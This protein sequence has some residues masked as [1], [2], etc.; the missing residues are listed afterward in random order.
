MRKHNF[1]NLSLT[2]L[3]LLMGLAVTFTSCKKD[4]PDP[5]PN[6]DIVL[7][8]TY[9]KG[10][11]TALTDYDS[12]GM[13]KIARN[14]VTQEDRAS[15]LEIYVAVKGGSDG[16]NIITVA[17]DVKTIMGPG[18]DFAEVTETDVDEPKDGLWRGSIVESE[19]KFTVPEDGLYH[20][21]YD[22]EIGIVTIAKADWGVIGA[23]TPGG[24]GESTAI[25]STGF[26]LNTI[27][28]TGSDI[29]MIKGDFKFR[30]SNGW[31]V[32]LDPE[33]DLGDGNTGIK[34]NSN[35]GGAVDNLVPGGANIVND[36]PGYYTI[37]MVWTIG[38]G[39]TATVEKTGD[40]EI[41]D[42][43]DTELGLVGDGLVV[44]G[45]P[46]NWD[47]TI[48]LSTPEVDGDTYTWTYAGVE[49]N[50]DGSFKIREGQDWNG[51]SVGY[52]DVTMGGT[53]ANNFEGTDPDGNFKALEAGIFDITFVIDAVTETYTFNV[54]VA[55]TADPELYMLGDG[56]A[57]GWDAENPIPM[58]GTDGLYTITADLTAGGE[59]IKFITT[60]GQWQPQYGMGANP[61]ELAVNE[62]SGGDDPAA[63]PVD[64]DGTYVISVVT[65]S[66]KYMV[67]PDGDKL[68]VPGAYQGWAPDAAPTLNDGNAD[69]VYIGYVNMAEAGEFKFTSDPNWDGTNY[70]MGDTEG[71]LST[72]GGAGNIS[73]TE[74]GIYK[75]T[76]DVNNL[77]YTIEK[78]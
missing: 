47:E 76:V 73:V 40:L 43:T 33:Y 25:A 59:G 26:D 46:H 38:E 41:I 20:I 34:V 54:K 57:A 37:T 2:A 27:T 75:F 71:T 3:A 50:V 21:A 12:K 32:I 55:G 67:D 23:A 63:I 60:L 45:N 15:L 51:K 77:T 9:I 6:P 13:M 35:F 52:P 10:A 4:D 72:D 29:K 65:T 61:G 24:W 68:Y 5:D 64:A 69:G 31:K 78:Q 7:D 16:F 44:D 42:Y 70:G 18:S 1:F 28:F 74:A 56:C 17:G 58:D 53:A 39:Y 11:G 19:S 62:V 48:M 66:M 30:Y 8:G 14:E 36:V 22:T 49:V